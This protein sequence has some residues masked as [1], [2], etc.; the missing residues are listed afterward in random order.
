MLEPRK[1]EPRTATPLTLGATR[2]KLIALG[3]HVVSALDPHERVQYGPHMSEH[4][5][6]V[7]CR[8]LVLTPLPDQT[9]S[10]RVRAL[11]EKR[12][13]LGGPVRIG[14]DGREM[15]P[16]R[17]SSQWHLTA[18][19]HSVYLSNQDTVLPLDGHWPQ[20]DLLT[21]TYAN[22]PEVNTDWAQALF[23]EIC[24]LPYRIAE[25]R[26]PPPRPSRRAWL[27]GP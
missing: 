11:L 21:V 15:R 17:F 12:G 9:L 16:V 3:Y 2:E 27:G 1:N 20:A 14:S 23:Q 8:A 25:E 7:L 19:D 26:A 22:V 10:T 13:L 4:L 5:P 18:L 24:M 6:A